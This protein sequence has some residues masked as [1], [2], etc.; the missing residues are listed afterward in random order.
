MPRTLRNAR[1]ATY[2]THDARNEAE[3]ERNDAVNRRNVEHV[4][5]EIHA[6]THLHTHGPRAHAHTHAYNVL[7][8]TSRKYGDYG[9]LKI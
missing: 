4:K 6:R 5:H 8:R 9:Y 3:S 1:Q 7:S 2:V